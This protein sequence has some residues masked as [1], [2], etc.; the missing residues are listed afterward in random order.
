MATSKCQV[1]TQ[2]AQMH[3]G[4]K[5]S[6]NEGQAELE[7]TIGSPHSVCEKNPLRSML[8]TLMQSLRWLSS[9]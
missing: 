4:K 7:N 5:V 6:F 2:K 8:C 9:H 3:P 1:S